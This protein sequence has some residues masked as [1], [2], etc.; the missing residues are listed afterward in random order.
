MPNSG[1]SGPSVPRSPIRDAASPRRWALTADRIDL[2]DGTIVIEC[3]KKRQSGVYRPVPV[4]PAFL[5]TLNMVHNIRA[6]RSAGMVGSR[7]GCGTG[8]EGMVRCRGGDNAY[9]L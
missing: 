9:D 8:D 6:R 7:S 5:D 1:K 2:K 4:P 3:K